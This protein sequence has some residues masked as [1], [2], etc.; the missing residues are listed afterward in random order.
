MAPVK[1]IKSKSGQSSQQQ[2]SLD[3][4]FTKKKKSSITPSSS[5]SDKTPAISPKRQQKYSLMDT[6]VKKVSISISISIGISKHV[7]EIQ[8]LLLF[9]SVLE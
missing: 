1:K 7:L 2:G 8:E 6:L 3:T 5:D 4:W 9:S